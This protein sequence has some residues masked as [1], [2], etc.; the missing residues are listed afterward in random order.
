[1]ERLIDK[2]G[3]S[4][5]RREEGAPP[6]PLA[7]GLAATFASAASTA[8]DLPD[9]ASDFGHGDLFGLFQLWPP[10]QQPGDTQIEYV[11]YL[12]PI[13]PSFSIQKVMGTK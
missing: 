11:L 9:P 10:G 5:G 3:R 12:P 4:S 7:P 8:S 1:M 13:A 2:L 6:V